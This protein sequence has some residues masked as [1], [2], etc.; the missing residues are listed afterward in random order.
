M[1]ETAD[2]EATAVTQEREKTFTIAAAMAA[3]AVRT[4]RF[5]V[6]GYTSTRTVGQPYLIARLST[7]LLPADA[8]ATAATT[9]TPPKPDF[10]AGATT[11]AGTWANTG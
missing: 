7:A 10:G 9:E 2:A 4:A 11:A 8:P 6:V 5:T 1:P 3:E